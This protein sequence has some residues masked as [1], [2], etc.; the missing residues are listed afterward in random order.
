MP[1]LVSVRG[2]DL[3][4]GDVDDPDQHILAAQEREQL[5]RDP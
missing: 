4:R 5:E 1:Q 3:V 2:L